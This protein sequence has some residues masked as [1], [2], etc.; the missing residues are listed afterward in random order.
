MAIIKVETP[1]G[2]K[3]FEIA[4]DKPTP[5]EVSAIKK[6]ISNVSS[7]DT[8]REKEP[9]NIAGNI[10]KGLKTGYKAGSDPL[11][12]VGKAVSDK[13]NKLAG[14]ADGNDDDEKMTKQGVNFMKSELG[15]DNPNMAVKAL[16]KLVKGDPIS[17]AKEREAVAPIINA[18]V[19]SL[20]DQNGRTRLKTLFKSV[21]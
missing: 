1:E 10:A 18:V 7:T 8:G 6:T 13:F 19:K 12:T 5:Q 11:G 3:E 17:N 9:T 16:Q 4:G 20:Q 15:L 14:G 2:V 21:K